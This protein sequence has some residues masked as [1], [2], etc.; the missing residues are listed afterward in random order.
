MTKTRKR[1]LRQTWEPQTPAS[2]KVHTSV[3]T[4]PIRSRAGAAKRMKSL[5]SPRY[6]W[7]ETRGEMLS[8]RFLRV[9]KYP[10]VET[11]ALRLPFEETEVLGFPVEEKGAFLLYPRLF[12]PFHGGETAVPYFPVKGK[13]AFL[14]YPRLFQP[15]HG[16]ETAVPYFPV[17]EKGAFLL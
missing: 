5:S 1:Q 6:L 2:T 4:S 12:R 8:L 17:E 10:C 13:E 14:L 9:W 15:F 11:G 7:K 3:Q 16:G